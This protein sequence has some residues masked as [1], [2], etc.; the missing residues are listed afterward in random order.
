MNDEFGIQV[1]ARL[2][3]GFSHASEHKFR[4]LTQI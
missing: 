3:L 4:K 2:K 1:L